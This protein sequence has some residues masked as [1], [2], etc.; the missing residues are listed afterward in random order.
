MELLTSCIGYLESIGSLNF[1]DL[2]N[3]DTFY[4]AIHNIHILM[5]PLISSEKSLRIENV[6]LTDTSFENSN[7]LLK[8]RILSLTIYQLFFLKEQVHFSQFFF[9]FF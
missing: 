7:F 3:V 5:S 9:F 4:Y 6:A 8:A 1:T 2:P